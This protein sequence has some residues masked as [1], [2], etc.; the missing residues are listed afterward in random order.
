MSS[1]FQNKTQD[2]E[3]G[4]VKL[5]INLTA[6]IVATLFS[7]VVLT[8]LKDI[9]ET[10][11]LKLSQV[12]QQTKT[13]K[14]KKN[15]VLEPVIKKDI[16]QEPQKIIEK[17]LEEQ[18]EPKQK[19]EDPIVETTEQ[20]T[21]TLTSAVPRD[22][23]RNK[24]E[25]D[26]KDDVEEAKKVLENLMKMN[27]NGYIV[28]SKDEL[29]NVLNSSF[30]PK[31]QKFS[32]EYEGLV[33]EDSQRL[34]EMIEI[35]KLINELGNTFRGNFA[36][37]PEAKLNEFYHKNEALK[38]VLPKATDSFDCMWFLHTN[39]LMYK[40]NF[41]TLATGT[42][43]IGNDQIVNKATTIW[44]DLDKHSMSFYKNFFRN[45]DALLK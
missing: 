20:T 13:I 24:E 6:I 11:K 42:H 22:Y 14:K 10:K 12:N 45:L 18:P 27:D 7:V 40:D 15:S 4:S 32:R 2:V 25:Q 5:S 39:N 29:N 16:V 19:Q 1:I 36:I 28:S 21:K 31:S 9:R 37:I 17:K 38:K 30:T 3:T 34:L 23:Q 26:Y 8:V 44:N 33:K 43:Y 35:M 41:T